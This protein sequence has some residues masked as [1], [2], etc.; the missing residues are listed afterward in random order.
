LFSLLFYYSCRPT[1]QGINVDQTTGITAETVDNNVQV[2]IHDNGKN[3]V[4]KNAL[5][6]SYSEIY[7]NTNTNTTYIFF[8]T[9]NNGHK[10]SFRV[11]YSITGTDPDSGATTYIVYFGTKGFSQDDTQLTG[12]LGN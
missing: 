1:S 10:L 12:Q 8:V 2:T 5:A 6:K 11:T 9:D 4:I 7:A 3:Y